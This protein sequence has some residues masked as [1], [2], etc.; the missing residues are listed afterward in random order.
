M[1]AGLSLRTTGVS[2]RDF[3]VPCDWTQLVA[4]ID[5]K[6]QYLE[7]ASGALQF[8]TYRRIM[9]QLGDNDDE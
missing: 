5:P 2:Q 1:D 6:L 9:Q 7:G 4:A 8:V 3:A